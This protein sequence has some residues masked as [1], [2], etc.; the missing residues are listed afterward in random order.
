[1]KILKLRDEPFVTP[2]DVQLPYADEYGVPHGAA[3]R[4]FLNAQ[5]PRESTR[6]T[7]RGLKFRR[8]FEALSESEKKILFTLGFHPYVVDVRDQYYLYDPKHYYAAQAAGNRMLRSRAMTVDI[9]V[10][11]VLPVDRRLRYHG[12]SVKHPDYTADEA[13]VRREQREWHELSQRGWTWELLRG[14]AV[15]GTEYANNFVMYR[16]VRETNVH[17]RYEEARWFSDVLKRSSRRGTMDAVFRR[18][19]NRTGISQ[20][21]AHRLLA[22]AACFGFIEVD[23]RMP[24]LPDSPLHLID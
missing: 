12:V 6:S 14:D 18:I 5:T 2:K 7:F 21:D 19:S 20:D 8:R 10:T 13:D 3:Y 22:V 23:H 11:Y 1:M 4:P 24:L 17:G 16:S 15:T 9:V